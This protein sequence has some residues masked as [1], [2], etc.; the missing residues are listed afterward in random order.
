MTDTGTK[1]DLA[2]FLLAR[3]AEDEKIV[4]GRPQQVTYFGEVV[5]DPARILVECEAKR[6]L[7]EELARMEDEE[8]GW[9][10]IEQWVM[11][12]LALPY[13]DHEDY[14]EEWKPWKP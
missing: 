4:Q 5:Y 12:Y 11:S 6:R 7:V 9:D 3:F 14:Q 13:A 1:T 2:A 10:G 8:M